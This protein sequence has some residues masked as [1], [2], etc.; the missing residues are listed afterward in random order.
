MPIYEYCCTSCGHTFSKLF[1]SIQTADEAEAPACPA[2][3]APETRRL[4]SRVAVHLEGRTEPPE[5]TEPSS[6]GRIKEVF[7]EKELKKAL[8]ERGY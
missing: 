1:H 8:A 6:E 7:G 3:G 4:I 2:C 5:E